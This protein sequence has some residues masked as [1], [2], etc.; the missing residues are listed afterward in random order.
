MRIEYPQQA[1]LS[2]LR[3]LWKEAFADD[4]AYLDL[5]FGSVFSPDRCRCVSTGGQVSAALYWLDCQCQDRP[6]AYLY[7]IATAK[8]HR[9]K[10]M[11]AAL[12]ADTHVLLRSLGYA[13]CVLVPGKPPLFR[14][15]GKMGYQICSSI[16][17]THCTA[18]TEPVSLRSLSADEYARLRRKWLP[19]GGVVQE[20]ENLIFL[21]KLAHFYAGKDFLLCANLENGRLSALELLGNT[22]AAP[23]ILA[24]LGASEGTFRFPGDNRSFAM[25][26]P[27]SDAPA[28]KYFAF[29]FD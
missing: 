24:A 19:T 11:C 7:A 6:M 10:G 14:M 13:G 26:H 23:N 20:G 12:I 3:S 18:G 16:G 1:Q 17:Q 8:S 27:L 4:D 29:A 28:P 21:E 2:Q 5:F 15:Y 25:Y 9:G 22:A